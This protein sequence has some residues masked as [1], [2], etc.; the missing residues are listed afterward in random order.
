MEK[1]FPEVNRAKDTKGALRFAASRLKKQIGT[2]VLLC[3]LVSL[4]AV[5]SVSFS[6]LMGRAID[7][8]S[9]GDTRNMFLYLGIMLGAIVLTLFLKF[10]TQYLGARMSFRMDMSLRSSLLSRIMSRDYALVAD[11]HSGDLMN[12]LTNDTNVV[13]GAASTMLPNICQMIARLGLAFGLLTYFDWIFAVAAVSA[14]IVVAVVS[15][16]ARPY[17]KKMHRRMLE[18][19]GRTR[20]FM[21]ET[22]DNQLVVRV[23]DHDGRMMK[24]ADELQGV[25][26]RAYMKRKVVGILA[27]QGVGFVFT[28]GTMLALTWGSLSIAGV[29]GP[30]RL[31]TF[32]TLTAVLQLV[33]QVQAPFAGLTGIIPQFFTMTAS[34]ERLMEIENLPAEFGEELSERPAVFKGAEI[35]SVSFSYKK[36]GTPVS[37]LR[38][39]SCSVKRGDYIAITGISGIGKS[40]L[41]KLLLGVYRPDSGG[42]ALETDV[43]ILPASVA[44]RRLFAYVPQGNMLL[45]GTVRENIAFW[46]DNASEEDIALAAKLACADGFI[47]ELPQGLDTKIGEHG[48][49]LS[50]GQAQRLAVAR[51][52]LTK[53]PVLLLDEATSALDAETERGLLENLKR[54]SIETVIIITHKTAAL[55]VCSKELRIEDGKIKIRELITDS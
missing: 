33:G 6:L 10:F 28:L 37:V 31:I 47:S 38:G 52:I 34:C 29:L 17:I 8:A 23:F 1:S 50:E 55:E 36:D 14:S 16:I 53:A 19:E 15:L 18:A 35:D 51:A 9:K 46:S 3:F 2:L 43:G 27:S 42:I 11:Y 54:S 7:Y 49:G 45:S 24:K 39:A 5:I 41:M 4:T 32:G 26:F 40:T 20:A 13:S 44:C 48:H 21:Q 25:T 22:I 30:N 12:R